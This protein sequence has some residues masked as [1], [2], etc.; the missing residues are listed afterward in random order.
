MKY[1]IS[2]LLL[3]IGLSVH[4]SAQA[5]ESLSWDEAPQIELFSKPSMFFPVSHIELGEIERGDKK[6]MIFH[7]INNGN[8]D[9]NIE[10]VS[11]CECTTLDWPRTPIKSGQKGIITAYFDSTEKDHGETVEIDINLENKDPKTGYP[12]FV[13]VTYDFTFPEK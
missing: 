3:I 12:M 1:L 4:I 8:E 11:G 7:F 6:E 5:I 2:T 10:I 9:L 13:R